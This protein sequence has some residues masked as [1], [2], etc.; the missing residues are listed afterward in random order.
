MDSM[1]SV[2][3]CS[4]TAFMCLQP[5]LDCC[6]VRAAVVEFAAGRTGASPRYSHDLHV[7]LTGTCRSFAVW[8][9]DN[10]VEPLHTC[11]PSWVRNVENVPPSN[12]GAARKCLPMSTLYLFPEL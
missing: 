7:Q 5:S 4:L 9:T 3:I 12:L 6:K 1:P 8:C 10:G 11:C 2:R